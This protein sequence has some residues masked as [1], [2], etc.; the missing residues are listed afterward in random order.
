MENLLLK[1]MNDRVTQ[2][3][4]KVVEPGP[5][6]TISRELGCSARE[7]AEKLTE[8]I[9]SRQAELAHPWKWVN[10][11]ILCLASEELKINPDK[12]RD[13][14][15]SEG[16]NFFDEIVSSFTL[17]Y[18]VN[19]TKIKRVLRDVVRHLAI[20]GNVVIV[21]RGSEALTQDILH[22]LHIKLFAPLS[23]KTDVIANRE[24]ISHSEAQK[25]VLQTDKRRSE[26]VESF[27][28]KNQ[29]SVVYDID[30]NCAKF[31]PDEMVEIILKAAEMKS[32]LK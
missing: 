18:Y 31:T 11:E 6:I 20:R 16:K 17:R 7:L 21:G 24:K 30:F 8:R 10:K 13:L 2:V 19:D 12:V 32:L 15:K 23:W 14:L 26:F 4:K 9:N 1:Y 3:T 22:S 28:G 5:V 27:L 25:L 29:E